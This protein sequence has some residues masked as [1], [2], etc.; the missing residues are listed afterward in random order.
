MQLNIRFLKYITFQKI[1]SLFPNEKDSILIPIVEAL[2]KNGF[3]HGSLSTNKSL[4]APSNESNAKNYVNKTRNAIFTP[5][6]YTYSQR[7]YVDSLF[8]TN[9]FLTEKMWISLGLSR[10]RIEA[11]VKEAFVSHFFVDG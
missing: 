5:H 4:T 6:I 9:G 1:D 2:C 8:Q 7:N 11:F 3:L 10:N